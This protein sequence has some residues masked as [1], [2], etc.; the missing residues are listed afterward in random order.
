M[1]Y[2]EIDSEIRDWIGRNNLH[3]Y[4]SW[5]GKEARFAYVSSKAGECF[6]ISIDPPTQGR[7][8][9][10]ARCVDGRRANDPPVTWTV[11]FEKLGSGLDQAFETVTG[12]M[13]PSAR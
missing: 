2:E 12:W 3:L 11:E 13:A 9:I 8:N 5:A 6:Q 1:A 10:F 4:T 7:A